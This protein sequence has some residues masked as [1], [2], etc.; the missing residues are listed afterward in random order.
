VLRRA[1]APPPLVEKLKRGGQLQLPTEAS[2]HFGQ[3]LRL[4]DNERVEVFDGQGRSI[5]GPLRD[6]Q[7]PKH[8]HVI[9]EDIIYSAPCLPP[10]W[11]L[12]AWVK[13]S[14]AEEVVQRATEMG[15][16]NIIFYRAERTTVKSPYRADRLQKIAIDASR[17]SGRTWVP[18][19]YDE[20]YSSLQNAYGALEAFSGVTVMASLQGKS[21]LSQKLRQESTWNQ[22]VDAGLA[23]FVGPEGGL[24]PA[25]EEF[26]RQK[27]T[28]L[29]R[30]GHSVLRTETAALAALASVQVVLGKM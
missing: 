6:I 9:V 28:H 4:K 12:Q 5:V 21:P 29:V 14:K 19:V 10:L 3:V 25:E 15:A 16:S 8:A 26:A 20:C 27:G 11:I 2:A 17:Q 30:L 23:A 7:S 1:W 24:T 18:Q 22:L 13:P